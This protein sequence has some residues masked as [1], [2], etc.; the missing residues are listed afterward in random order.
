MNI[1]P[2]HHLSKSNHGKVRFH[3]SLS[4]FYPSLSPLYILLH[5]D[6]FCREFLEIQFHA[7]K[8]ALTLFFRS[9]LSNL[10]FSHNLG[11]CNM[12]INNKVLL[13]HWQ[14]C[15]Q[16][17]VDGFIEWSLCS[18]S[19]IFFIFYSGPGSPFF[20]LYMMNKFIDAI[21]FWICIIFFFHSLFMLPR[22]LT[23]P[24]EIG[25]SHKILWHASID[26]RWSLGAAGK[27]WSWLLWL[28]KWR[29]W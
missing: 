6:L 28:P 26:R 29:K 25:C 22:F 23:W 14:G 17:F 21:T 11:F 18:G 24:I 20:F 15:I 16:F 19:P 13:Q 12:T 10:W 1:H 3:L 5:W 8:L 2:S 7:Y 9:K 4:T 27:C